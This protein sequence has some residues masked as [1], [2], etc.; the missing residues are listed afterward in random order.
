MIRGKKETRRVDNV[1]IKNFFKHT[2]CPQKIEKKNRIWDEE[3]KIR[4]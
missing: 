1:Q 3:W 2:F 4:D